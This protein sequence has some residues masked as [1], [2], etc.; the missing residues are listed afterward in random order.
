M[1]KDNK[2]CP[3]CCE[4]IPAEAVKCPWCQSTLKSTRTEADSESEWTRDHPGRWFLG[5]AKSLAVK[6]DISVYFWR[7]AF[8]IATIWYG[9]GPIVYFTIWAVTPFR[10]GDET[11]FEQGIRKAAE[12]LGRINNKPSRKTPDP[13]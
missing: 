7:A 12:I 8:I 13:V 3:Y 9:I 6:T 2:T 5:V 1:N 4:E 11:P 10:P